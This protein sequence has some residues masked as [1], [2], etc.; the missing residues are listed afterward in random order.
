MPPSGS[1][2]P[3]QRSAAGIGGLSY[4][5]DFAADGRYAGKL[6]RDDAV[7]FL[8]E[9]AAKDQH[10]FLY[11]CGH[12]YAPLCPYSPCHFEPVLVATEQACGA[13]AV[14]ARAISRAHARRPFQECHSPFQVDANYSDLYP[15]LP[16]GPRRILPG[17]VTH[18]DEMVGDIVAT[19]RANGQ[20]DDTLIIFSS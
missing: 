17:M 14:A 6:V 20:W 18:T 5:P 12:I 3:G 13:H 1:S 8:D 9:M 4:P 10:F 2:T 19:L 7:G 11:L 15:Q 16:M